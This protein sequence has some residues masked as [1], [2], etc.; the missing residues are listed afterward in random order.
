[1]G[2]GSQPEAASSHQSRYTL[3]PVYLLL[4]FS[5]ALIK[6]LFTG[7]WEYGIRS[8]YMTRKGVKM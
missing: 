2:L 6:T 7:N 4:P 1:M 8:S 5:L 3:P